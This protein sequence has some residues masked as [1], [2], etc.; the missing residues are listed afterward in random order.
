MGHPPIVVPFIRRFAA[1]RGL[2][3]GSDTGSGPSGGGGA[4]GDVAVVGADGD[5]AGAGRVDRDLL[6]AAAVVGDMSRRYDAPSSGTT[7][8]TEPLSVV[9]VTVVGATANSSV[10]CRCRCRR[11]P[12]TTQLV[13]P[14]PAVVGRRLDG[15]AQPGQLDRA[16]VVVDFTVPVVPLTVTVPL[17]ALI[18]IASVPGH[19]DL[20]VDAAPVGPDVRARGC[21]AC[22][23]SPTTCWRSPVERRP[24]L[25]SARTSIVSRSLLHDAHRAGRRV[26]IDRRQRGRRDTS[27][28]PPASSWASRATTLYVPPGD[29]G[30]TTSTS[31]NSF[32]STRTP[33]G[34][35]RRRR[36]RRHWAGWR[37]EPAGGGGGGGGS[38]GWS[39]RFVIVSSAPIAGPPARGG[40]RL[41]PAAGRAS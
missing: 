20:V 22:S 11:R 25:I 21:A 34:G 23:T 14:D 31:A 5:R 4:G 28:S 9:A 17:F 32:H 39:I 18:E 19:R 33:D 8:S 37:R 2:D 26:H 10:S 3:R 41:R 30:P 27:T 1:I 36:R 35:A 15:P 40:G 13:G 38:G 6:G 24:S 29:A 16:V 12:S 7:T